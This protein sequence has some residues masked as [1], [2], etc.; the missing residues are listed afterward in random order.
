[1]DTY[2][3]N[4]TKLGDFLEQ[5]AEKFAVY[6]PLEKG[7]IT[8][9]AELEHGQLPALDFLRT[10]KPPKDIFYPQTEVIL[11]FGKDGTKSNEYTGKP[12]AV[13]GARPCD[14]KG[15]VIVERV[16]VD[17]KY[18][19]NYWLA[20]RDGGLV[21]ALGCSE[22]LKSCFCNWVGG[23]PFETTGSDVLATDVGDAFILQPLTEAGKKALAEMNSIEKTVDKDIEKAEAIHAEALKSMPKPPTLDSLKTSLDSLF[24]DPFWDEFTAKCLGCAA[25]TFSCPTC[26]CF[27]IQDESRRG[28]GVR[29][30]IWDTC[31]FPLFTKEGSGHN[32]RK[33][34]MSR[35]RQRFMHKFSYMFETQGEF[36]CVGCGRCVT[37]CPVNIDVR[38]FIRKTTENTE[39]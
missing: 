31:Q 36:G 3:L 33:S 1:M 20:R 35:L 5:L 14:A 29:I 21:I 16:F 6:A 18:K 24:D 11:R 4:K 34:Q 25:C 32:P 12:I 39:K 37:A 38:E 10:Q 17:D 28:E 22:P 26:Y 27:D 19:D 2:K 8:A 7:D 23:G 13:F 30:R 15:F 9:F